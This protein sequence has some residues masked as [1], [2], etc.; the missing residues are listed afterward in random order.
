MEENKYDI[1]QNFILEE[2]ARTLALQGMFYEA[3]SLLEEFT[4][5][6]EIDFGVE[7]LRAECYLQLG[8]ENKSEKCIERIEQLLSMPPMCDATDIIS[9]GDEFIKNDFRVKALILLK[10]SCD[11]VQISSLPPEKIFEIMCLCFSKIDDVVRP[12]LRKK[13]SNSN[14]ENLLDM[15]KNLGRGLTDGTDSIAKPKLQ[16][17]MSERVRIIA[18]DFGLE[19]L[20]EMLKTLEN[21]S[22]IDPERKALNIAECAV[23]LDCDFDAA[24]DNVK[25]LKFNKIGI[26]VLEKQFDT[27]ALRYK[28]YANLHQ[29]A[30]VAHYNLNNFKKAEHHFLQAISAHESAWDYDD[31]N[32]RRNIIQK[33]QSDLKDTRQL[34]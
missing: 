27:S 21:F 33:A 26:E 2:R 19:Y 9:L 5:T 18:L 34:L 6:T 23:M 30:G 3:T 15:I 32:E 20:Q 28:L 17:K 24:G 14:T 22:E 4:N 13:T 31:E 10:I 16:T 7:L 25:S 29:N 8:R 11:I 12:I 1:L